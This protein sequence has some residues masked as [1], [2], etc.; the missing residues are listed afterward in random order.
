MPVERGPSDA[1]RT[2]R[3]GGSL[4]G[5]DECPG[6]VELLRVDGRVPAGLAPD[7][8]GGTLA[9]EI[10]TKVGLNDRSDARPHILPSGPPHR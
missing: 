5:G 7:F 2:G 4:A 1:D 6:G 9:D 3:C 8:R 10:L